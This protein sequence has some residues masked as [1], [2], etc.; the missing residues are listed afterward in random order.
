M[1]IKGA[2]CI[3]EVFNTDQMYSFLEEVEQFA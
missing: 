2:I 1:D 3:P